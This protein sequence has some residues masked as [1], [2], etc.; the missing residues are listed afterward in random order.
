MA[1]WSMWAVR[2][3]ALPSFLCLASVSGEGSFWISSFRSHSLNVSQAF[4]QILSHPRSNSAA[5]LSVS[6]D[7]VTI[8]TEQNYHGQELAE[9]LKRPLLDAN[10]RPVKRPPRL[11]EPGSCSS[12]WAGL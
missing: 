12:G 5:K 9:S 7:G 6:A 11:K 2:I 1:A 4:T 8:S 3:K 10:E